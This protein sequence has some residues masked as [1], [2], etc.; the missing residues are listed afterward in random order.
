M[1]KNYLNPEL[2]VITLAE[3]DIVRTSGITGKKQTQSNIDINI[4]ND[5]D[6][7]F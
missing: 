4:S 6:S 5:A 7:W 1:K 3:D 2:L